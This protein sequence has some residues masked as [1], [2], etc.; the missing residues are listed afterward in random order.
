MQGYFI[1]E[2]LLTWAT[3]VVTT[4]CAEEG[5]RG[6]YSISTKLSDLRLMREAVAVSGWSDGSV[7]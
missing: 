2:G 5:G 4:K 1:S 3:V 6:D 7:R